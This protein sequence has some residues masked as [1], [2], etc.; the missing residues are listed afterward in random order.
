LIE[1]PIWYKIAQFALRVYP[2][3][4]QKEIRMKKSITA[5][6]VFV[7]LSLVLGAC[8]L[9][10]AAP[11]QVPQDQINT[12]AAQ[13]VQ[14]LT[15]QMAPLPATATNTPEPATNT[16][17]PSPTLPVPTL[18][19]TPQTL[20]TNTLI[21]LPTSVAASG[22][23]NKVFFLSDDTIP[24]G[25]IIKPKESFV[26]TWSIRNDGSCTW[27]SAYMASMFSNDPAD[28]AINGDGTVK[29][30]YPIAPGATWK[31]SANLIAPKT[32]GTYT[33]YWK[34]IDDAGNFFGIGGP[35]GSAW[36]VQI[37]VSNSGTSS[38]SSG[39]TLSSNVSVSP[40]SGVAGSTF[41]ASG[42]VTI[43]G[44]ASGD[45]Q[46]VRYS[47]R[48]DGQDAGCGGNYTFNG[49]GYNEF[50]LTTC[51]IPNLPQGDKNVVVYINEPGG[52]NTASGSTFTVTP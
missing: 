10:P 14:A 7:L 12:I 34:M 29:V 21:P 22:E 51:K 35:A 36:S 44:L 26:K 27:S 24:D 31:Y 49:N 5:V 40:N 8:N 46:Y 25:T 18:N 28:P 17:E 52:T 41:T 48:V 4:L 20:A 33:Q 3:R 32:T 2:A 1:Q 50:N 47:I 39:M 30:T 37:K 38:S 23:C 11:T 13:T 42:R 16:P 9:A 15:T 43:A 19:L 6:S 45:S